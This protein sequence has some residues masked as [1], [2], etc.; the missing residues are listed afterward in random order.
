MKKGD[1]VA[2]EDNDDDAVRTSVSQN[3]ETATLC[4]EELFIRT[5]YITRYIRPVKTCG[6]KEMYGQHNT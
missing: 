6:G 4:T 1:D 5:Q 3:R 2:V